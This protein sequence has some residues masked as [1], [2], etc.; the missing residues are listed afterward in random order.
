MVREMLDSFEAN[1]Q[2]LADETEV[3][4]YISKIIDRQAGDL[5]GKIYGMGH[6]VYT[7]SDPRAT[8]LKKYAQKVTAGTEWEREFELISLIEKLTPGVFQ[9]KKKTDR[10]LC[11][12]V[13]L[14]SGLVYQALG[15]P[16]ELFTPLF[17]VSRTVGWCAHRI[18]ELLT[19]GGKI[20]RPGYKAVSPV[21]EYTELSKR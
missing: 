17:A 7:L 19:T 10:P 2:N 11:A 13:D 16:P 9:A 5:S 4:A 14:Y 12:N 15:I 3:S 8:I 1:V 6:A 20:I 21:L 18:E